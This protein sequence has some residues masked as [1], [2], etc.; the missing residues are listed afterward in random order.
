MIRAIFSHTN[1]ERADLRTSYNF[2]IDPEMNRIRK[3]KFSLNN[4][5]GLLDKYELDIK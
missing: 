4:L 1:L 2:T 3:A 5:P